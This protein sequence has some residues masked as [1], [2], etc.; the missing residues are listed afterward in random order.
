MRTGPDFCAFTRQKKTS[1]GAVLILEDEDTKK[2]V[3]WGFKKCAFSSGRSHW[4]KLSI[5][6]SQGK[7]NLKKKRNL[8][9]LSIKKF[10][11]QTKFETFRLYSFLKNSGF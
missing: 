9:S 6:Y 4:T 11:L 1:R 7:L 3:Y 2:V 5:R 8:G 10:V